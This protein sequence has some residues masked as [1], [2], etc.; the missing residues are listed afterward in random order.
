MNETEPNLPSKP[1]PLLPTCVRCKDSITTGHAYELGDDKWHTHCFSCY[2][3][4]KLLSCDSDFLV[5]GTGALICFDC[6]DSCK[7]CGKKIDD[8]AIIL[9]SS[10]EAYC[11]DCFKCCKC[12][13]NITDL[14]YAKTKRGLFC[15][16]CH[17]KLLAKRKKYEESKRL[18]RKSLPNIP[19]V[20]NNNSAKSSSKD[21][22]LLSTQQQTQTQTQ[23]Q[24]PITLS[25]FAIPER[26][27][28]RPISPSR[29][30]NSRSHSRNN[31]TSRS[32]NDNSRSQ[33]QALNQTISLPESNDISTLLKSTSESI[34][35]QYLENEE[36]DASSIDDERNPQSSN[37][38]NN[39]TNTNYT[40]SKHARNI[41]IDDILNSTLEN[42]E[43]IDDGDT[44]SIENNNNINLPVHLE[45]NDNTKNNKE[46]NNQK[47]SLNRTPLRNKSNEIGL[48][49]SP[50]SYRRGMILSDN[51]DEDE[52]EN[53]NRDNESTT[54]KDTDFNV[55]ESTL[56]T[57]KSFKDSKEL[58]SSSTLDAPIIFSKTNPNNSPLP[59]NKGLALNLNPSP[60]ASI[61]SNIERVSNDSYSLDKSKITDQQISSSTK[62]NGITSQQSQSTRNNKEYHHKSSLGRSLS[63]KSK[64]LVQNLKSKTSTSKHSSPGPFSLH[65]S[66][67][68]NSSFPQ[69][70]NKGN[71][72]VSSET[73]TG[74][75]INSRSNTNNNSNSTPRRKTSR[76]YSDTSTYSSI[77]KQSILEVNDDIPPESTYSYS[78][79][80][81]RSLSHKRT[82][83]GTT[84][85]P[86]HFSPMGNLKNNPGA[87]SVYTTPPLDNDAPTFRKLDD[88]SSALLTHRKTLSWQLQNQ[89]NPQN[90]PI[91][92]GNN[93][94]D[95][96]KSKLISLSP[97]YDV[98]DIV[99]DI[100]MTREDNLEQEVAT[101]IVP[102]EIDD[103]ITG[104]EFLLRKLKLDIKELELKKQKLITEIDSMQATKN[105]L[106]ETIES[107]RKEKNELGS[108]ESLDR[109][110]MKLKTTESLSDLG[111]PSKQVATV[112][113]VKPVSKPR[114]WKFFSSSSS[115]ASTPSNQ[116]S[117][118]QI[119]SS[120]S[121]N[122]LFNINMGPTTTLSYNND[123][124]SGNGHIE[125]SPPFLR[126]A[127][128]ISDMNLIPLNSDT[129]GKSN[130]STVESEPPSSLYGSTL[131][132]R[133]Q[134]EQKQFPFVITTC[135]AEIESTEENLK[136][137]GLYRKSGSQL[138]IEEIENEFANGT[139]HSFDLTTYDIHVVTSILKRYLRKLYN[140]L[141]TFEIYESLIALVRD[142]QLVT[143]LPLSDAEHIE[144]Q[145]LFEKVLEVLGNILKTLPKQ[146]LDLLK[147][148]SRHVNLITHFSE[149]NLM[150]MNNLALVFAPGLIRDLTGEKD[151]SDIKERN[152]IV[153]FIFNNYKELLRH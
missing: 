34:V 106:A 152:Y 105:D 117:K 29:T 12:G 39:A 16:N 18:E 74:W 44:G 35:A 10:N 111:S 102:T 148:L 79:T 86:I 141:L 27:S 87:V 124:N 15:L 147:L 13:E 69:V 38:K 122:Q 140:P 28:N 123:N 126:N 90:L 100:N 109:P 146:H 31:S 47:Q 135:L 58:H 114:F 94:D 78:T 65:H 2:K 64:S 60:R 96:S 45:L 62:G 95:I 92:L 131:V 53:E 98:N 145:Q 108:T 121:S 36:D 77:Q 40:T 20:E 76:G 120:A 33:S 26:A 127:N 143:T 14:R 115:S 89:R 118:Q 46:I 59:T 136:T 84:P 32:R 56:P 17:E 66:Q 1:S 103:L 97:N 4:D 101:S 24:T 70:S 43:Y 128:E 57:S 132:D 49:K 71:S 151:I 50:K 42:D 107:L 113:V 41:S 19:Q 85:T 144:T 51:E 68:T 142:N 7:N 110:S 23:T 61:P 11:S 125:I 22:K 67:S 80:S 82:K 6:S 138:V 72:M 81:N 25:A 48:L 3:C 150:N 54:E 112:N 8:L 130:Q 30:P 139:F 149:W 116:S 5:L 63:L 37:E 153:G 99:G 91:S 119:P 93:N 52:S 83:S 75:G 133:C 73:H 21:T 104:S 55:S 9:S 88:Q 137:E 129:R 134:Y